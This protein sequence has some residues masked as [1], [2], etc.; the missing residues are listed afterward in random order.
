MVGVVGGLGVII[1]SNLNRGRLSCYWVGVGLGYDK[2]LYSKILLG[3]FII[4][5]FL[6]TYKAHI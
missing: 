6:N 5:Y 2:N 1:E 3:H 4:V